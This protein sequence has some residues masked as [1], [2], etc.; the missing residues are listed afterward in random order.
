MFCLPILCAAMTFA[1]NFEPPP[2]SCTVESN[3]VVALTRELKVA[4]ACREAPEEAVDWVNDHLTLWFGGRRAWYERLFTRPNVP[5]AAG[6]AW[7]GE[8]LGKEGYALEADP[9]RILLRAD[10]LQGIRY[11][12]YTLR[13]ATMAARGG[14]TVDHYILPGLKVKDAPKLAFRGIHIP[15]G[16]NQDATEIEKRVRLAAALK[17]NYAIIE[18]WGTF[19]SAR[20]PWWGWKEGRMTPEAVRHLVRVGRELGITLCPQIP[21]FGHAS[22]GITSPGKHAILDAHPEYQP[23][24]E[25]LN[26]WN[27]CLSNPKSLEVITD[28]AEEM[29]E[30]FDH[31]PY[32]HVGCDEAAPPNCPLCVASDYR[33]LVVRHIHNLHDMLAKR[34]ARMMLWHDMFLQAGDERWKGFYANGSRE[35]AD[36][37]ADLP[38]DIVICDWFYGKDAKRDYP[39]MT[40]FKKLGFTV[41]TCPWYELKGTEAQ[42]RFAAAN[43]IDGVLSTTWGAGTGKEK[44]KFYANFFAGTACY[45]WSLAYVDHDRWKWHYDYDMIK[46]LRE[47][48][49]DM[50]LE[51]YRDTGTFNDKDLD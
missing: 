31:P 18:P 4:V 26:G 13:H 23:L 2:A 20:H 1:P 49:W 27:W 40:M 50:E 38:R 10:T 32:F 12:M 43:G 44:G 46:M 24:F 17:Y 11:A 42:C 25:S 34:G 36:A 41:L 15:W 16:L 47:V 29:I 48:A 22:M 19:R 39:S 8:S 28:L 9:A 45:A 33:K 51:D 5:T 6:A 21:A 35:T 30:L 37:L 3:T 14:L 7:T